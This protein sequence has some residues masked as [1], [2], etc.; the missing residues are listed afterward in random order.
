MKLLLAA[1][2][3][4]TGFQ[5]QAAL[6]TNVD[7]QKFPG[8]VKIEADINISQA[9]AN[10]LDV[11]FVVDNSGSMATHQSNLSKLSTNIDKALNQVNRDYHLG[12]ISTDVDGYYSSLKPGLLIGSPKVITSRDMPGALANNLIVG[13]NGSASESPFQSVYMALS[14][15]IRSNQNAG[16]LR[17]GSS[18]ALVFLTDAEDQSKLE[19]S[20]FKKFLGSV[21]GDIS[22]VTA[23]SWIVPSS[24]SDSACPRDDINITPQKIEGLTKE[25]NGDVYNLCDMNSPLFMDFAQKLAQFGFDPNQTT[26]PVADIY[27]VPLTIQ[28]EVSTIEVHYGTQVLTGDMYTGWTYDS[29]KNAIILGKKVPWTLQPSGTKLEVS[30]VPSDWTK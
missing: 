26:V 22:K 23:F 19:V 10:T 7:I 28:P 11:L 3:L 15:P 29:A 6:N 17:P 4:A 12:I 13:I 20:D 24:I 8:K 18:L 30:F 27:E 25:L 21:T 1:L 9:N 14:E 16:F 2:G 5:A